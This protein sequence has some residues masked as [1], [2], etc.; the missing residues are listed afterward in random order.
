MTIP[1]VKSEDSTAGS[2]CNE[3]DEN[4]IISRRDNHDI[5][6]IVSNN[7]IASATGIANEDNGNKVDGNEEKLEEK[8]FLSLIAKH[9]KD[10]TKGHPNNTIRK[11]CG[12]EGNMKV[13][14]TD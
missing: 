2:R 11:D 12:D 7:E 1:E 14:S 8:S 3:K 13:A 6:K 9:W 4:N 10:E 5:D